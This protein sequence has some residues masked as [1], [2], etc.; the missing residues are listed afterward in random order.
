MENYNQNT[1]HEIGWDDEISN[2]GAQ[3]IL[4]EEGDYNFT[5]TNFER[6]RFPGS[7]KIPPC[8]KAVLTLGVDTPDGP[9]SVKYDL[10]LWS[11]LEWKLSEFFR[12]I[13]QKKSG[14]AFRPNWNNVVGACGRA[15]FKPRTYEKKDGT[16]SE[17]NDVKSFYDYDPAFFTAQPAPAQPVP[18]AG[19]QMGIPLPSAPAPSWHGKF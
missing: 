10:I 19:Q 5:V 17:V 9:A 4:L 11:S 15:R 12:A 7:A 14:E 8:N 16:T 6:G 18:P 3:F 13:G 2:D 1:A